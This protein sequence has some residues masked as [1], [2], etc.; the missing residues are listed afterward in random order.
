MKYIQLALIALLLGLAS[1]AEAAFTVTGTVKYNRNWSGN[2]YSSISDIPTALRSGVHPLKD[3]QIC[4][5]NGSST[6]C[7]FTDATG[8]YTLA[9]STGPATYT[10][11]LRFTGQSRVT[12]GQIGYRVVA[13]NVDS[14]PLTYNMTTF[15]GPSSGTIDLANHTIPVCVPATATCPND[16]ANGHQVLQWA[17][18]RQANLYQFSTISGY[19]AAMDTMKAFTDRTNTLQCGFGGNPFC[20]NFDFGSTDITTGWHEFGHTS[21]R[22]HGLQLGGGIYGE[23]PGQDSCTS[24]EENSGGTLI[25]EAVA[26]LNSILMGY[27]ENIA[28]TLSNL[29]SFCFSTNQPAN[30]AS[31]NCV[32]CEYPPNPNV[33]P[34]PSLICGANSDFAIQRTECRA[35]KGFINL[36][37]SQSNWLH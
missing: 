12:A 1:T 6:K 8:R 7:G 28:G 35:L 4:V 30:D 27:S 21:L 20:F 16:F 32:S 24:P 33:Y 3:V 36:L 10:R 2:G 11:Q 22:Q 9:V 15:V 19:N 13:T 5:S 17:V 31:M 25:D 18:D 23:F 29:D 34:Q 14:L 37:D 26:N